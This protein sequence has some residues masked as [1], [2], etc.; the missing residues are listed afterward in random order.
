M[1]K[2]LFNPFVYIAGGK[3]LLIGIAILLATSL[4]G[5]MSGTHFPDVLSVKIGYSSKLVYYVAQ[6]IVNWL[7]ISVLLYIFALVLS[8]SSVRL[9]DIF[10]TQALARYPYFIAGLFSFSPS[11]LEFSSYLGWTFL[12]YGE[13]VEI[14]N[15]SMVI[16]IVLI[17][18]T[19]AITV[20]M[21]ALMFN[22]YKLAANLKGAKLIVSFIVAIMGAMALSAYGTKLL[23]LNF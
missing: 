3:S 1:L 2:K 12:H 15:L 19:I 17:V 5:Y 20:W 21:V 6:G 13:P 14:S 10:G 7:S 4:I 23:I 18:L 11:M 22:A 8:K 16:A 9:I